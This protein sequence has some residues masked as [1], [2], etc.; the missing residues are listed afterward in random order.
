MS[1]ILADGTGSFVAASSGASPQ[2]LKGGKM[3]VSAGQV[4]FQI[5]TVT[6]TGSIKRPRLLNS[7]IRQALVYQV[8]EQTG[9]LYRPDK[10][11][12]PRG[13]GAALQFISER[14]KGLFCNSNPRLSECHGL[15]GRGDWPPKKKSLFARHVLGSGSG[16]LD[17]KSVFERG[18]QH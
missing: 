14:R 17:E 18:N 7:Y 13:K 4:S 3:S 8:E 16:R 2:L 5:A 10:K 1:K 9:W 15:R 11:E 6:S 12:S